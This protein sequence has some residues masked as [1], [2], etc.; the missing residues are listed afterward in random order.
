MQWSSYAI[1]YLFIRMDGGRWRLREGLSGVIVI[2]L[3]PPPPSCVCVSSSHLPSDFICQRHTSPWVH[4]STSQALQHPLRVLSPLVMTEGKGDMCW[5][6]FPGKTSGSTQT[7]LSR[8]HKKCTRACT[9]LNLHCQWRTSSFST[10]TKNKRVLSQ[11]QNPS[12]GT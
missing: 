10:K 11:K 8:A 1:I 3:L 2:L 6:G 5:Q 7:V 4:S 9:A 12:A